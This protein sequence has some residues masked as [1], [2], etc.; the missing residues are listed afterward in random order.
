MSI[1]EEGFVKVSRKV[2]TRPLSAE[3]QVRSFI[4][5]FEPK[6]QALFRSVR[7]S[8]RKRFPTA[9]ELVYDYSKFL[10]IGYSPTGRGFES[11]FAIAASADGVRLSFNQGPALP[12]PQK[13]LLGSGK[14]TRF[15]WIDSLATLKRP[16]VQA[17]VRATIERART[18]FP[19]SGR[20]KLIIKSTSE[21]RRSAARSRL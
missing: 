11:T 20:G 9:D 7:N 10:V 3:Q 5:R 12:D 16:E 15:I 8:L 2:R 17:L 4:G 21:K 13:I 6:H 14:Q 19:R 1:R 18:P